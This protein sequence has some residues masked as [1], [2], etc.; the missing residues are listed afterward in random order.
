[1]KIRDILREFDTDQVNIGKDVASDFQRG[2]DKVDRM[3]NPKRWFGIQDNAPPTSCA[4]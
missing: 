2:A 3:L 4:P 1:M